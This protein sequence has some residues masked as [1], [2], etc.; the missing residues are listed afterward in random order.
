MPPRPSSSKQQ[1]HLSPSG[2]GSSAAAAAE[3]E[4]QSNAATTLTK[5][6]LDFPS[7]LFHECFRKSFVLELDRLCGLAW[8]ISRMEDEEE[9]TYSNQKHPNLK[10]TYLA[11][12]TVFASI[13]G[14]SPIGLKYDY[15]GAIDE[16]D[17]ML[18]QKIADKATSVYLKKNN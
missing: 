7:R 5:S 10:G 3:K 6:I 2:G 14:T 9:D 13:Y 11:A 17:K 18:L 1:Q 16:E 15:Y 4:Q 12:C 8:E